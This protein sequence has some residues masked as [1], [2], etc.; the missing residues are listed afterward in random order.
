ITSRFQHVIS[1][2]HAF[3]L[4]A[5]MY[6]LGKVGFSQS[7][8][9]FTWR[10]NKAELTSYLEELATAQVANFFRPNFFVNTPDINPYFLQNSGRSGF[11]IRARS[12]ERRVGKECRSRW[13]PYRSQ[14]KVQCVNAT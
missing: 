5:M 4:P 2:P 3:T 10:N 14:R 1:L 6:R 7:Y 9:Y 11:L 13:S 8:T 12:E